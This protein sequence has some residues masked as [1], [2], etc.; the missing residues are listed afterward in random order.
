MS[1]IERVYDKLYELHKKPADLAKFLGITNSQM[2]AWKTRQTD[3]PAKYITRIAEF[4]GVTVDYLLTGNDVSHE[5]PVDRSFGFKFPALFAGL[6][7]DR[8]IS[9]YKAAKDLGVSQSTIK[10]WADGLTFPDTQKLYELCQYFGVSA[11]Y[12][13]GLNDNPKPIVLTEEQ[14]TAMEEYAMTQPGFNLT[15]EEL[16]DLLPSNIRGPIMALFELELYRIEQ[17]K[18]KK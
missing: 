11:D 9:N 16:A 6:L 13:V 5:I 17:E 15:K 8:N 12:L 2:S 7:K 3:P 10:N 1:I 14:K 18:N 4:L